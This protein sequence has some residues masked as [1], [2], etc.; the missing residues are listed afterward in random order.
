MGLFMNGIGLDAVQRPAGVDPELIRRLT[1]DLGFFLSH[2]V[3][4]APGY[5]P[6][7]R[8]LDARQAR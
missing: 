3:R 8:A 6:D 4:E 7:L 1:G 2:E 5:R